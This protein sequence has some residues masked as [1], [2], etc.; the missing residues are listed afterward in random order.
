VLF[1]TLWQCQVNHRST[2]IFVPPMSDGWTEQLRCPMCYRTGTAALS[3]EDD[4]HMPVSD[5]IPDGFEVIKIEYSIDFVC[6][7]CRILVEP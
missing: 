1:D 7:S 3:Q 4:D 5:R 6:S 2:Y